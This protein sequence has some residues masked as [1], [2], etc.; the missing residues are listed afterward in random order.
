MSGTVSV[1]PRG[2]AIPISVVMLGGA[3]NAVSFPVSDTK[4]FPCL[5]GVYDS[6]GFQ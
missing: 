5:P 3:H 6:K 4:R 1:R 2:R